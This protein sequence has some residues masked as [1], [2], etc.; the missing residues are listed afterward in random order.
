MTPMLANRYTIV[1]LPAWF[2]IFSVGW[3]KIGSA[4]WKYAL[5]IMLPLSAMINLAFFKKH[6]TRLEKDQFR[7]ASAIV[8]SKNQSHYPVYS[9][10]PWHFN[11]Y[12]RNSVDKVNQLDANNLPKMQ[13]FWL[14]QGNLWPEQAEA[15]L[16]SL[17]GKFK[18]VDQ[19]AFHDAN[20]FLLERK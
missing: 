11:F 13:R 20:A 12:F 17:D 8:I 16:K 3:D 1:A 15:E 5:A 9:Q 14:L 4:K 2:L 19:Y 7:E 18:I 6:Y 10:L